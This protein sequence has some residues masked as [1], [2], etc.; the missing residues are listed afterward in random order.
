ML[1]YRTAPH[2]TAPIPQRRSRAGRL[3][4]VC[5]S[6][7]YMMTVQAPF[8]LK[9]KKNHP[10][11]KKPSEVR[12]GRG[13]GDAGGNHRTPPPFPMNGW[14]FLAD[15]LAYLL[16]RTSNAFRSPSSPPPPPPPPLFHKAQPTGTICT[17][18]L[19]SRWLACG[20]VRIDG[21]SKCLAER[22]EVRRQR[23]RTHAHT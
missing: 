14:G 18:R 20:G 1:L 8:R 7:C 23:P 19:L 11:K 13:G 21:R 4:D 17:L 9:K 15:Y 12:W 16:S 2:R 22:D 10:K 3:R 5:D 6:Q